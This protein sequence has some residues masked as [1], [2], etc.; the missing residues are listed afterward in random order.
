MLAYV[1]WHWRRA[2]VSAVA[3]EA[4]QRRFHAALRELRGYLG[5]L[6]ERGQRSADGPGR[7]GPSAARH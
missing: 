1:F 3:Y 5:L 7:A 4:L 2:D 6:A